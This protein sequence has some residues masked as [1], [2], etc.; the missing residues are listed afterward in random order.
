MKWIYLLELRDLTLSTSL[1]QC[2]SK[3]Y[4]FLKVCFESLFLKRSLKALK[5]LSGATLWNARQCRWIVLR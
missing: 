4:Y 3:E 1:M 2:L 5:Q